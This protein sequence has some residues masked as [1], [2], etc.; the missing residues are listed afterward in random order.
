MTS[1][2][3]PRT[4]L[5]T[6]NAVLVHFSTV[7]TSRR[8]LLFP[9]DIQQAMALKGHPLS[10]STIQPGDTSPHIGRGGAEGSI[11]MLVD[12]GPATMIH[13]VSPGDSGSSPFGSLG[14]PPSEVSC[15]ASIDQ[16]ET[17]NEWHVQDYVPVGIFILP[18][19]VVLKPIQLMGQIDA[20]EGE[21][22]LG[23]AITPFPAMRI[24][25][26]N[27]DNYLEYDRVSQGWKAI[28]YDEIFAQTMAGQT[29]DE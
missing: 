20:A 24:F 23:E 12:I 21:I 19:I 10:F 25:T 6:R 11:G 26:A 22:S 5:R 29:S 28:A 2:F 4:F 1:P 13:S 18:P 17:S 8:D 27:A 15:A 9:R 7:M 14:L 16:R 3:L